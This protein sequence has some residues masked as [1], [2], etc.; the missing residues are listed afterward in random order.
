MIFNQGE[1]KE[2]FA[3]PEEG[4]GGIQDTGWE[5]YWG[6]EMKSTV[7]YTYLYSDSETQ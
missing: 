5:T 2:V 4:A 1:V 6:K 7:K 3:P